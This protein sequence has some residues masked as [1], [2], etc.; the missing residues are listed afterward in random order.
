MS[1][2]NN[3]ANA[4][5]VL[6]KSTFSAVFGSSAR[7]GNSIRQYYT[8][9]LAKSKQQG[10]YNTVA[11]QYNKTVTY[12]NDTSRELN[13]IQGITH[14]L[15]G[16]LYNLLDNIFTM[17]PLILSLEADDMND[18]QDLCDRMS[19]QYRLQS[20]T[21]NCSEF[22][23][24][25]P[26]L[27]QANGQLRVIWNNPVMNFYPSSLITDISQD[28][29]AISTAVGQLQGVYESL[30]SDFKAAINAPTN[31]NCPFL[32]KLQEEISKNDWTVLGQEAL[33]LRKSLINS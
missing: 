15:I 30:S 26:P 25:I 5:F 18:G 20:I 14:N 27:N 12:I 17:S 22:N 4:L 28:I 33:A 3:G 16:C 11:A 1:I 21:E 13:E 7:I 19:I 32:K 10:D 29:T 23:K 6:P 2:S 31:S 8:N 24:C 9:A